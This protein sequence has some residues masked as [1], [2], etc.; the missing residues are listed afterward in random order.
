MSAPFF[1]GIKWDELYERKFDGPWLPEVQ[2]FDR[3]LNHS[4]SITDKSSS[5]P[6]SLGNSRQLSS[7]HNTTNNT[8]TTT[9]NNNNKT[10]S[11]DT[12]DTL[13]DSDDEDTDEDESDLMHGMRDSIIITNRQTHANKLVDWSFMDENV[14]TS[15]NKDGSMHL[16]KKKSKKSKATDSSNSSGAA[17]A[18]NSRVSM[19]QNGK[20]VLKDQSAAAASTTTPSSADTR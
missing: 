15:V 8:T 19:D 9:N 1:S 7:H 2:Y 14:L 6:D 3:S 18:Q 13:N 12:N 11:Q 16:K 10:T 17:F 4:S 5:H 20:L